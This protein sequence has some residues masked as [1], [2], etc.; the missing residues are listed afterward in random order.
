MK[1]YDSLAYSQE[2][3]TGQ[4]LESDES[5]PHAR[6]CFFQTHLILNLP[7]LQVSTWSFLSTFSDKIL[8]EFPTPTMRAI[9]LFTFHNV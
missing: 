9:R 5:N 1:A 3:T 2:L 7:T 8:Y 4:Y 6:V